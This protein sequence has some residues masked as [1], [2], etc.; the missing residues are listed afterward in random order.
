MPSACLVGVRQH[1]ACTAAQQAI[2]VYQYATR[3]THTWAHTTKP[4]AA[5]RLAAIVDTFGQ[6]RL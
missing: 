4:Q 5:D 6:Q 2:H 3:I 1:C